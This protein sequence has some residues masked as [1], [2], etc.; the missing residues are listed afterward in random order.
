MPT[1]MPLGGPAG[2]AHGAGAGGQGG[3][4][5]R[6]RA[7]KLVVPP[8]PHTESV[9][10]KVNADRIALSAGASEG[11]GPEPPDDDPPPPPGRPVVR[12]ITMASRD[13]AP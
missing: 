10:G 4:G 12:R 11:T 9:T 3:Q 1:G 13:D 8:A 5:P 7:K 2:A 6:P